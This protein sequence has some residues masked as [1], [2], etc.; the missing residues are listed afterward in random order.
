MK[1]YIDRCDT[2]VAG[3]IFDEESSENIRVEVQVNGN[4]NQS[5]VAN[6][7]RKDLLDAG[8][9]PDCGFSCD[10]ILDGLDFKSPIDIKIFA[11]YSTNMCICLH[12]VFVNLIAKQTMDP[13]GWIFLSNDSNRIQ[14]YATG[15]LKKTALE[16][17]AS[18]KFISSY[19]EFLDGKSIPNSFLVIPDKCVACNDLRYEKLEIT[20]DRPVILF[21]DALLKLGYNRIDYLLDYL[22]TNPGSYFLKTDTH[23]S[24]QG[25]VKLLDRLSKSY[26]D[27]FS[28]EVSFN[29]ILNEN[30]VGDLGNKYTPHI[31][32][33][34]Q[35]FQGC[36]RRDLIIC[37]DPVELLI[38]QGKNLTGSKVHLKKGNGSKRLLL[39]GTSSAYYLIF[40]LIEFFDEVYFR[41]GIPS[42]TD[43]NDFKPT[44]VLFVIPERFIP[45]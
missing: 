12:S 21:R 16:I 11:I 44:F 32:E 19:F 2:T 17:E 40:Y 13:S 8:Y 9:K 41:W 3:W 35:V 23:L 22:S 43:F 24:A 38:Q 33:V 42:V 18:A 1:F 15:V 14:D 37:D 30:F 26:P 34:V 10:L 27:H 25:C 7:Y 45:I 28:S 39:F 20:D 5:A 31:S 4:F 36:D 6:L 29:L